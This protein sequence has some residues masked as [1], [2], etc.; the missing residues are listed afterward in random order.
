[1]SQQTIGPVPILQ[2]PTQL[3]PTRF[4]EAWPMLKVFHQH[5]NPHNMPICNIQSNC[6]QPTS[7]CPC[8]Q[9]A[10]TSPM[11]CTQHSIITVTQPCLALQPPSPHTR[12]QQ[13]IHQCH[14]PPR[15]VSTTYCCP[16]SKPYLP[17]M[18][19]LYRGLP[20][21]WP[22]GIMWSNVPPHAAPHHCSSI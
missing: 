1:M 15:R 6:H 5:Y 8:I 20:L 9:P 22:L 18:A 11:P 7:T 2:Q 10:Y 13:L 4:R 12:N 16:S 19:L 21:P 14:A 17:T 3:V